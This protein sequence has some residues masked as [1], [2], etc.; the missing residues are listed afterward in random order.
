[1]SLHK[2][3]FDKPASRWE[4]A[5]PLGN[6]RIGACV[7][8]GTSFEKLSLN[9]ESLWSGGH[10][11][12]NNPDA[13]KT[14]PKV[15]ELLFNGRIAEAE[16]LMQLGLCGCPPELRV[17]QTLGDLIIGFDNVGKAENYS[18][19]L[20]MEKGVCTVS[21]EAEGTKYIREYFA[22]NV[23]N[24]LVM[25]FRTEG[26]G[27]V[28]LQAR[29]ERWMYLGSKEKPGECDISVSGKQSDD[30]VSYYM[31]LAGSAKGGSI[32][33]L[34]QSV[35]AEGCDEVVLLFGAATSFNHDNPKD[36]VGNCIFNGRGKSFEQL[37]A[38]HEQ[39]FSSLFDR[40]ELV[41]GNDTDDTVSV[42]ELFENLK[43]DDVP[44][45]LVERYFDFGRYLMISG[46]RPGTLP[47]NLQ[48]I[49]NKDFEPAWGSKYTINI[50]TEMNY[51]P[52]ET[53]NLS[54]CQEP[55][56]DL[57]ERMVEHGRTTAREMYGCRGF[58]A[59]HNTD[60]WGDTAPQDLYIPASYW[61]MGAAWLCTHQWKHYEYTMDRAFL[62]RAFPIMC[63]AAEFFV[64]FMV[65]YDGYLV[66]CPSVSPENTFILPSGERGCNTYGVTMDNQILRDLFEQ[67]IKSAEILGESS[68]LIDKIAEMK[69]KLRPS[70]IASNGTLMEWD[71]E[72]EEA[73]P[74]H[75]HISHL[76][77]L[78]PSNQINV[79]DTPE[80]AEAASHTLE[81]RLS[82]GGGHTGWSCA[83][84]INLYARLQNG[85]KAYANLKKLFTNST[86]P[87]LFDNHPP[88]QIDG[89]F[90]ATAAIVEMLVQ[91]RNGKVFLLPALPDK[92]KDGHI[93]GI[94]LPGNCELDMEWSDGRV[95]KCSVKAFSDW[96][97]TL[98]VNGEEKAVTLSAGE[99]G[100]IEGL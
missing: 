50:N 36:Y 37:K 62:K 25:R 12:R 35:V 46:S 64:D 99:T 87:N 86:L 55:L 58:V 17:Y 95:T 29:L 73:E 32:S 63:E 57:I 70:Q 51:W 27:K 5:V 30:G 53:C 97:A 84:I 19:I 8:G 33:A 96:K 59:H 39:D 26:L 31:Q 34:G 94:R 93:K 9:E 74:G 66:T 38:E 4:E 47:L 78:Y 71:K 16:K 40:A 18:R 72:Y 89:N 10:R 82:M 85:E 52:A 43:N 44:E 42:P 13:L 92:W 98:F 79:E 45:G 41:I 14:L 54:E 3:I 15:R 7:F 23:E 61:V 2:C 81:K 56:F 77:G 21:F 22:T 68:P 67:C 91:A 24:L 90:G 65:E 6:G 28:S 60:I 75:R 80:L 20:D 100:S 83:W 69:A 88:F 76:Y 48:G 11:N 1:M 49:W